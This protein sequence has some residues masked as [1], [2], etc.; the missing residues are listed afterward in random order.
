MHARLE[1][2][3]VFSAAIV[4]NSSAAWSQSASAAAPRATAYR[5]R[6][7]GVY[8]DATGEPIEGARVLDLASGASSLTTKTG[9]VSLVYLPDGGSLVRI[10]KIGYAVT[11]LAVAIG[12]ADTTPL[13]ITLRRVAELPATI[14]SAAAPVFRS[15]MLR[16]FEERRRAGVAGYFIGDSVLRHEESR[17]LADVLRTHA[18]GAMFYEGKGGAT[19]LLK[20]PRCSTGGPPQVYLDGIPL[21][22]PVNQSGILVGSARQA[23]ADRPLAFNLSEFVVS[24]LA[25]V[26]WYP[27]SDQI[28]LDYPHTSQRCGALFLWTRDR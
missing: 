18:P 1:W 6:L 20:S 23:A 15:P 21:P 4:A 16:A 17:R 5:A 7:L 26:E 14:T 13:T 24:D 3:L 2:A 11:T 9:T 28:P 10:Q 19:F 8:D 27:D 22:G 25:G 12:P